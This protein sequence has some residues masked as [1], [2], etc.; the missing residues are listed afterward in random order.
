VSALPQCAKC[1]SDN[2][3]GITHPPDPTSPAAC[4]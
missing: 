1:L 2:C 3:G 4:Q